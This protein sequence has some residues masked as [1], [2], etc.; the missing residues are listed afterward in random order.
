MWKHPVIFS[1]RRKEKIFTDTINFGSKEDSKCIFELLFCHKHFIAVCPI[2]KW[3][4]ALKMKIFPQRQI[5]R[6]L[7]LCLK[8]KGLSHF[9]SQKLLLFSPLEILLYSLSMHKRIILLRSSA[10]DTNTKQ[11][12]LTIVMCV[13]IIAEI[14]N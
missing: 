3:Q 7:L 1:V 10:T 5:H 14:C 6:D 11:P 8:W 12:S 9:Y 4:S 2:I 13:E